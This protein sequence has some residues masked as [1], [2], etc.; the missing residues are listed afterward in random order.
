MFKKI[1]VVL[2]ILTILENYN[3]LLVQVYLL[4]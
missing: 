1:G 3:V 2:C 4:L